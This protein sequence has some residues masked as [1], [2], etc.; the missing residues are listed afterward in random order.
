MSKRKPDSVRQQDWDAVESPPLSDETLA[1][2]R[3]AREKHADIVRAHERGELR[4]RGAQKALTKV[5][6]TIRLDR[7][8]I[9]H[10]R[11]SGRGWQTRLNDT[12]RHA[13]GK[14]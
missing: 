1:H 6:T 8:V 9:E 14:D 3:P 11:A 7:D 4:R 13:I 12:L 10:F 2:M 5:P